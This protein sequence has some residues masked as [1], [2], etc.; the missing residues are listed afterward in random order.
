[1][2]LT[3]VDIRIGYFH[4]ASDEYLRK[5]G[6]DR[7]ALPARGDWRSSYRADL[8]RPIGDRQGLALVW[9]VDGEVVG[10]STADRIVF[11]VEAYMHLHL[12]RPAD[13]R[14]GLGTEFVKRSAAHYFGALDLV[15]LYCE[16]NAFN[17]APN[18]TLQRAGFR[19]VLTHEA[20]PGPINFLQ[21]TNRW[22]MERDDP[23]R[24]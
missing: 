20:K 19:Y 1:M 18:R 23:G 14:R 15:R 11:G 4:G 13:R 6:V 10:F 24:P 17:A 16:P 12:I 7:A 5:L 21:V 22:V 9:E 8:G 2:E 3:E